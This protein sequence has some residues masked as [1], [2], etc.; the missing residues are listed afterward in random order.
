MSL[1][2]IFFNDQLCT[3]V[4]MRD[5]KKKVPTELLS[6]EELSQLSLES[7]VQKAVTE[8]L[9][10]DFEEICAHTEKLASKLLECC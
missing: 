9:R 1:H 7:E 6:E 2:D 10:E 4:L 8:H 3:L 5:K